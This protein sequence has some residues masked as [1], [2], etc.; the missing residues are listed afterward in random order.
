MEGKKRRIRIHRGLT[1]AA[2]IVVTVALAVFLFQRS[3]LLSYQLSDYVNSH[4]FKDTPFEFSCG[5]VR[6]DL[7]SH[8]SISRPVIRYHDAER[9]EK[10]FTADEISVDYDVVEL[11]KLRMIVGRLVLDKVRISVW[12][13]ES[14]KL[15]LPVPRAE[16]ATAGA[17][18]SPYVE[19]RRFAIQDLEVSVE[20]GGSTHTFKEVNLGGS[21]RYADGIGEIEIDQGRAYVADKKRNISSIKATIELAGGRVRADD[22]TIRLDE[23]L[24]MLS[25]EYQNGR[26]RRVRGIF[27]PLDLDEIF[28][29][30]WIPEAHGEIGGSVLVN[31]VRDSLAVEGSLTGSAIGLVFSGLTLKGLVTPDRVRLSAIQGQVHGARVDG[32]VEYDRTTGGYSFDGRCEGLDLTEGFIPDGGAPPTKLNGKVHLVYNATERVYDVEA[33]LDSSVVDG[34]EGDRIEFA[35]Q[36]SERRGLDIRTLVVRRPGFTLAGFGRIDQNSVL[37]LVLSAGGDSLDYATDYLKF[38]RLGGSADLT[39]KLVGPIDAFQVNAN[40]SWRDL[41]YLTARIDS[42][43]VHA[44]ARDVPSRRARGTVNVVGKRLFYAGLEFSQPHVLFEVDEKTVAVTDLSFSKGDTLV[45]ADFEAEA[46]GPPTPIL[47]KH[48]AVRTPEMTWRNTRSVNVV[49]TADVTEIDTLVLA[50]NGYE[51]GAS[52]RFSSTTDATDLALWGRNIDLTLVPGASS[53]PLPI[54]GRGRFD[55]AVRGNLNDPEVRIVLDVENGTVGGVPFTSLSLDGE[56]DGAAYR[57]HHLDVRAGGDSLVAFGTWECDRSPVVLAKSGMDDEEPW[58]AALY[59][60]TQ[61]GGFP[62][63]PFVRRFYKNPRWSGTLRGRAVLGGSLGDPRFEL[64]GV[65]STTADSGLALPDIRAD[66]TYEDGK[67][68]AKSLSVDDGRNKVSVTGTLPL[69]LDLRG[70]K[71]FQFRKDTPVDFRGDFSI[72]DLSIVAAHIPAVAAATGELSGHISAVGEA[73]SPRFGG[74]IRLRNGAFRLS[75]SDEVFR[76]LDATVTLKDNVATLESL[77]ARKDKKGLLEARGSAVIEGFGV[78]EYTVDVSCSDLSIAVV[79]G[80]RSVQTGKIRVKSQPGGG[81]RLIPALSG[82]LEVKEAVIT[83]SLAAQEGPPSPLTMPSET[84]TWLCD[85]ELEAPKNV[86]V[87]NPEVSLEMGGDLFLKRD[88]KG[89]YLRG[90]LNVLRGSYTLYNNRFRITSGR[91]DFATATTLRP[92]VYLDAYTPYRRAG[93]VEHKIFLALSWPPDEEAPKITLS[94]SEAGYSESDIWAMLG[95]QVVTGSGA[96]AEDG[97]WRASGTAASLASNYLEQILNAQMSDMTISVE[98]APAGESG[99]TGDRENEMSIAVGRYMSEDLYLN[100]RQGLRVSSAREIDI[101]YRL[102]N[103]LLLRSEIIQYSQKGLQGT[104]QQA[105]E[106]IN[107]DLKFRWEY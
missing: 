101:E 26:F 90:D 21:A 58:K 48:I 97:S 29:L 46:G 52:G 91:F 86:W 107:F 49:A 105:T 55:A 88:Q 47:I 36:W 31:G 64:A 18:V 11:L 13:D 104:N 45:T 57:L 41:T 76:D 94:Y 40:G 39:A 15:V 100:Y 75:G 42:G 20:K 16:Q 65:V 67:L 27:N 66:V 84:P 77:R 14:G 3:N 25:G 51:L 43:Q 61:A 69:G 4:Y 85:V 73:V 80:F 83:R 92:G 70:G 106:E 5:A 22:V 50:T 72:G 63:T 12:H 6:S 24:V 89:L 44:D 38:P 8:A 62:I 23:S 10:V 78:S 87:R 54:T 1:F 71:G 28:A 33:D 32:E 60:E 98:T 93:D 103:M 34:F 35:G 56:F 2:A 102:S 81:G 82:K 30:G 9:S 37:D 95:G 59:V 74:E 99:R 19:I 17:S 96:L 53:G 79:P 68:S 7:V